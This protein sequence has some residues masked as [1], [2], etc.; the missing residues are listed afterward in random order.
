MKFHGTITEVRQG[1]DGI[2]L[3]ID[4][5]MG[6]RGVEFERDLFHQVLDDFELKHNDDLIGWPVEYDPGHGDLDIMIP[7]DFE[8][9]AGNPE[10]ADDHS[11]SAE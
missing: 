8:A 11:P 6:L 10:G 2:T 4:T 3:I 9:H 7:D 5:E 1:R